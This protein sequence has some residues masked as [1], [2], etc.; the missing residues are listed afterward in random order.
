MAT[1]KSAAANAELPPEFPEAP[2]SPA[3]IEIQAP[4]HG[5]I[6]EVKIPGGARRSA[7]V[8]HAEGAVIAANVSLVPHLDALVYGTPCPLLVG[9]AN[10]SHD[11]RDDAP[12]GTWRYLPRVD[13][14][15]AV[16]R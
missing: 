5:R 12:V 6:V 2:P 14:K 4:S 10:L 11:G 13:G 7:Q 9:L 16:E 15:V 8:T 3:L 1:K